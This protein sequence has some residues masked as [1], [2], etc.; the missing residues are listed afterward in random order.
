[1]K[2]MRERGKEGRGTLKMPVLR[3]VSKRRLSDHNSTEQQCLVG[4]MFEAYDVGD[5]SREKAVK[6]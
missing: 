1:M 3:E 2:R 4:Y 6:I 5:L